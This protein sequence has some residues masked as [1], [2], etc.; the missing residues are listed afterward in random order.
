MLIFAEGG[1]SLQKRMRPNIIYYKYIIIRNNFKHILLRVQEKD[2][3]IPQYLSSFH[4]ILCYCVPFL[5]STKR[6]GFLRCNHP[7]Y[8]GTILLGKVPRND[9]ILCLELLKWFV[10][11]RFNN[12]LD[13][14]FFIVDNQKVFILIE[15]FGILE[16]NF[17]TVSR[18]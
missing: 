13:W 3:L 14:S 17:F 8:V 16:K 18:L 7:G 11:E 15:V 2:K 6:G 1:W 5:A 12:M 4:E 9:F 10:E